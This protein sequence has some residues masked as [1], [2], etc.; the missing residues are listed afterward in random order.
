MKG[1]YGVVSNLAEI[2]SDPSTQGL[3]SVPPAFPLCCLIV[4]ARPSQPGCVMCPMVRSG[5]R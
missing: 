3:T 2:R 1:R 4:R 5:L